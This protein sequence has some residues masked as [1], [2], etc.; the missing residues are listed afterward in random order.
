MIVV[1]IRHRSLCIDILTKSGRKICTFKI[2]GG[3][4][5][6]SQDSIYISIF[7][8]LAESISGIIVEGEC[9]TKYPD[10]LAM[11]LVVFKQFIKFIIIF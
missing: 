1:T 4:G 5:I 11:V 10:D 6:S 3:K 9:R 7:N 8:Q 2:M